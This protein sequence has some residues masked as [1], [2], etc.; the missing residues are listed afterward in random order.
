MS[1]ENRVAVVT[2][3]GSSIHPDSPMAKELGVTVVPLDIK[4]FEKGQ[5]LSMS[6][7]DLTSSELYSKM[8][9]QKELPQTS[10]AITGRIS[11]IYE[12]IGKENRSAIS[13][14]ITARH[15]AV[16]ES[17]I[18]GS[19]L[20]IEKNPHLLIEVIDS[21]QV[22]LAIWFLV[23]QAAKLANEGYPLEDIKR[24]VLE[25]VPKTDLFI[26]LSTLDN[27]VKGGRLPSAAGFLGSKLKLQPIIGL[28]NGELKIQ[29]VSRTDKNSQKELVKRVEN[30]KGEIVK[31]AII[32]TNYL[33]GAEA[34]KES[35][36]GVYSSNITIYEAGPALGVHAGERAVGIA[37]QKA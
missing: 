28:K 35:L 17:A 26:S 34:L 16:W 33:E 25:S 37:L 4:F 1:I 14:H 31:L 15:S 2:D 36:K 6:D 18:L 7:A 21:K 27:V 3:T 11:K 12:A 22:S 8:R 9:S 13:I 20:A 29:S 24:L 23:E 32:H 10:G 19:K 30:T 5:W